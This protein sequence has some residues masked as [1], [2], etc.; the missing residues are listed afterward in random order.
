MF[1]E[2][3]VNHSIMDYDICDAIKIMAACWDKI[4]ADKIQNAWGILMDE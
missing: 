1:N 2:Y 3:V 4:G